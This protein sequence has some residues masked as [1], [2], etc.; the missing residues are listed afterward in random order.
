MTESFREFN[1][2]TIVCVVCYGEIKARHS[3]RSS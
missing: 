1:G 2:M 3:I